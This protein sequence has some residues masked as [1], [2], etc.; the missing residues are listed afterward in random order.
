MSNMGCSL[1]LSQNPPNPLAKGELAKGSHNPLHYLVTFKI[2]N[3]LIKVN[4]TSTSYL[5][6]SGTKSQRAF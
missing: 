4:E 3:K 2:K 5:A 6:T 1:Y